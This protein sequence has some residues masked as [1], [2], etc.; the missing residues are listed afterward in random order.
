MSDSGAAAPVLVE[1]AFRH[2][3][4]RLVARLAR[5]FGFRRTESVEDAVQAALMAALLA[6]PKG[7]APERPSAWLY[8]VARNHLLDDLRRSAQPAAAV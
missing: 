3:Y 1:H 6:W 8:R 4:S 5:E 2:E 7:G